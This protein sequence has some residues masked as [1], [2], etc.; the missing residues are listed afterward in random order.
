MTGQQ[1]GLAEDV[2]NPSL[3]RN[4]WTGEHCYECRPPAASALA[5]RIETRQP[6]CVLCA[7]CPDCYAFGDELCT[8]REACPQRELRGVV[9]EWA[10]RGDYGGRFGILQYGALLC[11]A[12]NTPCRRGLSGHVGMLSG[13]RGKHGTTSYGH[14]ALV[15]EYPCGCITHYR[16]AP[17]VECERYRIEVPSRRREIYTFD[18]IKTPHKRYRYEIHGIDGWWLFVGASYS[19]GKQTYSPILWATENP[20]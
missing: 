14:G 15:W 7:G 19:P 10:E 1:I 17:R 8:C 18:L 11:M 2:L 4:T 12:V 9:V 13:A 5:S 3:M 16:C 20:A 6:V